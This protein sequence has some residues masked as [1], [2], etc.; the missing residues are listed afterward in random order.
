MNISEGEEMNIS[1]IVGIWLIEHG[2]DGL[3][4]P[5][6]S[7]GGCTVNDMP[8]ECGAKWDCRAGHLHRHSEYDYKTYPGKCGPDCGFFKTPEGEK[9]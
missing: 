9:E 4:A 1:E 7:C 3:V 5:D 2:F 8:C 6:A